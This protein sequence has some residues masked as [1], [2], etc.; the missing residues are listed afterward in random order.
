M[1]GSESALVQG[2]HCTTW[3]GEN[4]L[5]IYEDTGLQLLLPY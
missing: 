5:L 1:E 3:A 4:Y 2:L